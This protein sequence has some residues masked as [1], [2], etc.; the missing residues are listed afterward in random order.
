M[1]KLETSM[2]VIPADR[3]VGAVNPAATPHGFWQR[4]ARMLDDYLVDRAKR[5]VPATA[6]RRSRHDIERCR[7][8]MLRDS[9]MPAHSKVACAAPR[10]AARAAPPSC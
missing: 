8:L 10:R 1:W 9:L 5:T 4:L 6:F 3:F 2:R 7:R